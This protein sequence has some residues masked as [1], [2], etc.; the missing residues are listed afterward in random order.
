MKIKRLELKA[1]GPF[2]GQVLDFSSPLPGLH[3]VYGPNE[4]GKSSAMRALY[5]WFFGFP[6]RTGDNFI[7]QNQQLLVGGCLQGSDGEELTCYRRKKNSKDLF[8]QDD[9]P[10]DP[11]ALARY[12]HT[13]E[14]D[15]F[16]ALYGINHETLIRGGEGILDQ[17]GEVGKALFAAG[18]G[19]A[20]LKPLMDELE[21]EGESL[22]KPQGSRQLLNEALARHKELQSQLKQATL[23]GREW[24]EHQQALDDALKKLAESQ[25]TKQELEREKRRLER[26]IQAM[27]DLSERKILLQK[28]EEYGDVI[29]LPVDFSERRTVIEQEERA[30]R[31]QLEQLQAQ[32]QA[33]RE[34]MNALCLNQDVLDEAGTIEELHQR[35]GEYRKGKNDRPLREGQRLGARKAAADLLSQIKPGFS[36]NNVE[37]LRPG[38]SKRKTVHHLASR[39]EVLL[40]GS[41]NA[42]VQVQDAET[43]LERVRAELQMLP[44][45]AETGQLARALLAAERGADL[46]REITM[47]EKEREKGERE[48]YAL[49]NR[50]E[51]WKGALE[52]VP[53][54]ALPLPESVS[55][56]DEELREQADLQRQLQV[57]KDML[58]KDFAKRVEQLHNLELA[59]DL[60]VEEELT[61]SRSR[62]EEGWQLLC[63]QWLQQEDVVEESKRFDA[64]LPLHVAYEQMV[65]LSDRIADRLY[66]EADR[67]QQYS[68]MK[69]EAQNMEKRLAVLLEGERCIREAFENL[70]RRWQELWAFCGI[71]PLSP[72]EMIAWLS[73]F[74]RLR[75]QVRDVE[76]V[77]SDLTE[78]MS[79]RKELRVS[80][81]KEVVAHGGSGEFP[82]GE[83]ETL[84]DVA[85]SL[86]NT[87]QAHQKKRD[88][89]SAKLSD[90]NNSVYILRDKSLAA[91][92]ELRQ[93][94]ADWAES[95][96]PLGLDCNILPSEALDFLEAL[97]SCFER[98][99]EADEFRKRIEGIDRDT[100]LFEKDVMILV[101]KIAPDLAGLDAKAA[102]TELKLRLGRASQ[103][104]AILLRDRKERESLEKA[105]I[106]AE[107]NVRNCEEHLAVMRQSACCNTREELLEAEQ[108]S[109]HYTKLHERLFD[110]ESRLTRIAE[111]ATIA[112]LEA[113]ADAVDFDELPGRIDNLNN[114]ITSLLDPGIQQLSETIGRKRSELERMDGSGKAATLADALQNALTKIRRLTERY[115]RIKLAEKILREETERY[116]NE[117]EAPLLKMASRY[118]SQLT[119]GSFASLRTDSD[120][121]D[122]PILIG[123]RPNGIRLHVDAMSSGTRDQLYLALR[124]ATL[125]W[126]SESSEPMPF[127]VD[128]ILINF[129]DARSRATIKA[130]SNLA[131]K[132]QVILFT[133]HQKIVD[134][135]EEAEFAG[136]VFV[137]RLGGKA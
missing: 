103:D 73:S 50:L 37:T 82:G 3:I 60:P 36:L 123:L 94:R 78:K 120:D 72:R 68:S 83:L 6:V 15:L 53:H 110:I 121:H 52:L 111:G 88:V 18:A 98:L 108:R 44:S 74:D 126:R 125:E 90:I 116:R 91:E 65:L 42:Q 26:L 30:A 22:F 136:S 27:P 46:D 61:A 20:S 32:L 130:L 31:L 97:Q 112:N 66:H 9:H 1:F 117:N 129:D 64:A 51:L 134:I 76:K 48:C 99:R 119:I 13:L 95:V 24:E 39:Y 105:V 5:A 84:L 10:I 62:R 77:A 92:S 102:V 86:L 34:K 47:L 45:V 127:I 17:Q 16:T 29:I 71:E 28:L 19:L 109:L 70:D 131:E 85:R 49:L 12:L 128:D 35:L 7:H 87:L 59:A 135:A 80:L 58:E 79:R 132:S 75:L 63:R 133:H 101:T 41:R 104:Q 54:L 57:E 93:W 100:T 33:V 43:S 11:S 55:R 114:E 118:F 40:Q 8:D 69:A 4:A 106:I 89:M 25:Q 56:F 115:I 124:L 21:A 113:Q 96:S 2:S 38:L 137:H 107:T 122:N 81:L 14:K 67:V 23:S